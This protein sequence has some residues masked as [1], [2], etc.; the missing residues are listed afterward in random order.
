MTCLDAALHLA[1]L[2]YCVL[3]VSAQKKPLTSRPDEYAS[4][5]PPWNASADPDAIRETWARFPRAGVGILTARLLVV[6]EDQ[7]WMTDAQRAEVSS[8]PSA[9][10]PRGGVHTYFRAPPGSDLRNTA[11][12]VAKGVDTRANGG[13]IIVPPTTV[14]LPSGIRGR[15]EWVRPLAVAPEALPL[16]PAWVL[17]RL[18]PRQ[19]K[20]PEHTG[21]IR[22][23]CRASRYGDE[24]LRREC[25]R[26]AGAPEGE[27]NATLNKAAFNVGTLVAG[28]ELEATGAVEMLLAAGVDCGLSEREIAAS[29]RSGFTAGCKHPRTRKVG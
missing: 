11:G 2:G 26:V 3:P 27:R 17:D 16:P 5:L 22:L 4:D 19:P 18:K 10:T 14:A 25:E 28:G 7:P 24:A 23:V 6:D 9:R 1:G 29:V 12:V 20:R 21:P 15:Y 8:S 13:F